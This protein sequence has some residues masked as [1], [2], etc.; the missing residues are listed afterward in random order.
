MCCNPMMA[1]ERQSP[2]AI[3]RARLTGELRDLGV[4]EGAVVM[5]HVSMSAL[6]FVIG[7][8]ET[9]VRALLDALEPG[10]TLVAYAQ[11][12]E[13]VF[14]EERW[15][16][17]YRAAYRAARPV[18]DPATGEVRRSLG[19]FP[20]RVRTWPGALRSAHPD[21]SLAA[22]GPH[23]A[24]LTAHHPR[25]DAYGPGTPLARIVA[26]EGQVLMLGAPLESLTLLHHA[27]AL[28]DVPGKR[29]VSFTTPVLEDGEVRV[30]AYSDIDTSHG[31]VAYEDLDLDGEDFDVIARDA[32][33]AGIGT[34]GR[35]GEAACYVF[36]AAELTAFGVRWIE[37]R[38][39][40]GS[41]ARASVSVPQSK[42]S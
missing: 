8:S 25:D 15:P 16:A 34:R 31:A 14:S 17:A 36:G 38:F 37:E 28:A 24:A 6:G 18:F 30:R 10:G 4:R 11:W 12:E 27:E 33:A 20:E 7:G 40:A 41:P 26:A 19:R 9:V 35:V 23:A 42:S 13:H 39:G 3:D 1:G 32:L 5:A 2:R 29:R 21:A 22:V